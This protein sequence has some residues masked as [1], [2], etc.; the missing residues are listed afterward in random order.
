M[1]T[2]GGDPDTDPDPTVP[3]FDPEGEFSSELSPQS[4]T[5]EGRRLVAVELVLEGEREGVMVDD[6]DE[7]E[8]L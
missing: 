2:P 1:L 8:L 7:D 3:D 5:A 6:D 4:D